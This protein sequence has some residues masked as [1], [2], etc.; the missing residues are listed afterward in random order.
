MAIE[1][2]ARQILFHG[3]AMVLAGLLWGFVIPATPF[4]RLALTAHIEFT[5]NGVLFAVLAILLLTLSH[6]VGLRSVR[7]M[8]LAAWLTWL[9]LASEV[10]NAWW[11]TRQTLPLAAAQA[12]TTGAAPWQE[13]TVTLAHVVAGVGLVVAWTLLIVGFARSP[14]PALARSARRT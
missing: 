6:N 9:M 13:R 5:S 2:G 12:G 10:A 7:V 14:Q 11:G 8:Q 1:R 3:L 4:P